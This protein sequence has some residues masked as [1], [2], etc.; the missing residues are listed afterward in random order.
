MEASDAGVHVDLI[1]RGICCV[2]G[3]IPGRTEHIHVR[4]IVGRYLEHSRI[5]MFGTPDRARV[6][7][8]SADYMP[9]NTIHRVEVAVP[10]L[11]PAI[12][13]RV[14]HIFDVYLHDNCKA[15]LQ[16]PDGTYVLTTPAEGEES[17][18]AQEQL[19]DEAYAAA[20]K[21]RTRKP[22]AKPDA[23]N[24]ADAATAPTEKPKRTRKP[25]AKPD[26]PNSADTATAPAEKPKR[27]RKPKAKPDAAT[28]PA[29]KPKRTRK[30]KAKPDAATAPTEKPKRGRKP[31]AKKAKPET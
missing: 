5:Y 27:G 8:G 31:R 7:I 11:D 26:A 14:L 25:K 30:P 3:G 22:A 28:A 4:S 21:R 29:E 16:Q 13:A 15:R 17:R 12:R 19:F 24:P 20:P 1:V 2:I 9:R 18:N 10:L 6:Y 23:P